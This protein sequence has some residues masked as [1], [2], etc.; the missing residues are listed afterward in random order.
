MC[1]RDRIVDDGPGIPLN[2]HD[3]LFQPF[4]STKGERGTGLGL[5]I[6]QGII[7]KHG[8][9]I[10]LI[11]ETEGPGRGTIARVF[12]AAKPILNLGGD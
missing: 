5:W 11:S 8:G 1:I 9:I 12:L 2:V 4:F 7:R 10:D 3:R 6:C